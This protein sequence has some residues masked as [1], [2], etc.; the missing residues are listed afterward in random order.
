MVSQNIDSKQLKLV[1][2]CRQIESWKRPV[3]QLAGVNYERFIASSNKK[4]LFFNVNKRG[5]TQ[6][7]ALANRSVEKNLVLIFPIAL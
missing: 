7:E 1:L 4:P 6:R 3:I 2:I 5:S